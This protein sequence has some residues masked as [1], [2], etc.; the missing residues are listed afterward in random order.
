MRELNLIP[1]GALV[2]A[3]DGRTLIEV[4]HIPE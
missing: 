3:Q 1:V 4:K 2:K